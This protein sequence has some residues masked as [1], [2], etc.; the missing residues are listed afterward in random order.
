MSTDEEKAKVNTNNKNQQSFRRQNLEI[1]RSLHR[2]YAARAHI[3]SDS[4]IIIC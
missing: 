2:R 3:L 4:I 1:V